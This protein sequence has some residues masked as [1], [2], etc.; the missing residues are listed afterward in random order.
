MAALPKRKCSSGRRD[1]RRS[2]QTLNSPALSVCPKCNKAK[3]PHFVCGYCGF[4]GKIE[5]KE[6]KKAKA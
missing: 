5:K 1:R 2:Q 6:T 4:Y 3:R